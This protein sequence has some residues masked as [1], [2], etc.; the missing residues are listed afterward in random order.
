MFK[1]Y[2]FEEDS[3]GSS[4]RCFPQCQRLNA[5]IK[6]HYFT[7]SL[8]RTNFKRPNN[9]FELASISLGRKARLTAKISKIQSTMRASL[10]LRISIG[11][12]CSLINTAKA[13]STYINIESDHKGRHKDD[14]RR[15]ILCSDVRETNEKLD[16][17]G[18]F[19][20]RTDRIDGSFLLDKRSLKEDNN[21]DKENKNKNEKEENKEQQ[22]T[23]K[24]TS[25]G[26]G[27]EDENIIQDE[28]T[29]EQK[30]EE[31]VEE[32]ENARFP[33]TFPTASPYEA[34]TGVPSSTPSVGM[35]HNPSASPSATHTNALS[36]SVT[37]IPSAV[38]TVET[39][40][41]L[42]TDTTEDAVD[43]SE[44]ISEEMKN[45]T[46]PNNTASA[47]YASPSMSPVAAGSGKFAKSV[48]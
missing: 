21:K 43:V 8:R 48:L 12:V 46:T 3:F 42:V 31:N 22:S 44:I 45:P 30:A 25:N 20:R 26:E 39:A 2:L 41:P 13:A 34:A 14:T 33:S 15:H 16:L 17:G 29:P 27:N 24:Q 9:C 18:S 37:T 4:R 32:E 6:V 5:E 10:I 28:E 11:C 35:T 40:T 1:S 7:T 38:P 47:N 23:Q 36:Y 19:N